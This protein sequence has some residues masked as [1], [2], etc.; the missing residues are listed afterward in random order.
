LWTLQNNDTQEK[1]MKKTTLVLALIALVTLAG[2]GGK[3]SMTSAALQLD[4][5]SKADCMAKAGLP[6]KADGTPQFYVAPYS[7]EDQ[8]TRALIGIP[9]LI[10]G[11]FDAVADVIVM[12]AVREAYPHAGIKNE[13]P[14]LP[15]RI[16]GST[17]SA[18]APEA[19]H[20]FIEPR[21]VNVQ[22]TLAVGA[23]CEIEYSIE[24]GAR[25]QTETATG[26]SGAFTRNAATGMVTACP[27]M[28]QQ[29]KQQIMEFVSG[30]TAQAQ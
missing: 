21:G 3:H 14:A 11:G 30:K 2:C 12:K 17:P 9:A 10:G 13:I 24:R 26:K 6:G 28:V 20:I 5:G 23:K 27:D 7:V 18:N 22:A 16:A 19:G 8:R 1:P 15:K 25:K 29:L 4:C